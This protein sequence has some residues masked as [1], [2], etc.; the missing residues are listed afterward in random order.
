MNG[1]PEESD[2]AGT[3]GVLKLVWCI[4]AFVRR[5]TGLGAS[6]CGKL[7]LTSSTRWRPGYKTKEVGLG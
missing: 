2:A 3:P 1:G 6:I 4:Q 7:N 5:Q